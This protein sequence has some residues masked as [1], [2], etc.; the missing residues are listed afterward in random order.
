MG[1]R[2]LTSGNVSL[3]LM[4]LAAPLI[5][6]NILQQLYN[7]IDA[8]VIGRYAGELEFAAIGV[9][10]SVMNLFLFAV[11]G[12]CGGISVIFAQQYGAGDFA[13]FRQ[14]H[15]ITVV[16]G[17]G[18]VVV[19]SIVGMICLPGVLR[20]IQTPEE[21]Y[22]FVRTYLI[23]ILAGLPAAF[24][25][26]LYSALLRAVGS[27]TAALFVLAAAVATN[28]ILDFLFVAELGLGIF[29]AALATVFAQTLSAVLAGI[30]M[31]R[32][33]PE[34]VFHR[35][36]CRIDWKLLQKTGH[37]SLTTGLH[38]SGLYIGKLLVQGAV[39]TG[40]TDLISAYTATTRIE[41]FANSFGDSGAS[42]TSILVAQ[43]YGAKNAKR[44]RESFWKS[45]LLLF[46]LG[47]VCSAIMYVSA[48]ST[49]MLLLRERQGLA[50]ESAVSYLRLI[51]IFY[52]FCF[53][54][55]TFAGYFDGCGKVAIPF[56]GA[57]S[58]IS[59]RA[60]LSW[61]W[62]KPL[63]LDAVAGATGIG[64]IL[65]N[66]FWTIMYAII[67]KRNRAKSMPVAH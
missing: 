27:T 29:G 46:G 1:S 15:F 24:L 42:A 52:V 41:G 47:V 39:N 6:G 45:L 17:I 10:A 53:T 51:S 60:I 43:N 57:V 26:N 5:F 61:M 4:Q 33:F 34:L 36:D 32:K 54:G 21:I 12:A 56:I 25:Y 67:G 30:Y 64:W 20:I 9:S 22:G 63:G 7:T 11:V 59:F 62:I 55:N 2:D 14:E 49:V 58:H 65:V 48:E 37:F 50:F 13:S 28:L 35:T 44:V 19:C 8:L 23:V 18:T 40:G 3:Q 16:F 31:C 66:A 38:Q